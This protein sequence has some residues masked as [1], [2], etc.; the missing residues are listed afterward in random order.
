VGLKYAHA[1]C[2]LVAPAVSEYC[3]ANVWL[4]TDPE[5]G[6]VETALTFAA[7]VIDNDAEDAPKDALPG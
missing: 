4:D 7:T 3:S 5:L 2:K 6:V 1:V